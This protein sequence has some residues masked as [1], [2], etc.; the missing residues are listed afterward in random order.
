MQSYE[1]YALGD[2]I[3]TYEELETQY[4]DD[5]EKLCNDHE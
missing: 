1:Y 5:S 2:A 3:P 4:N